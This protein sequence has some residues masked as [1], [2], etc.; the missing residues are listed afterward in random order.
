MSC[1]L[2]VKLLSRIFFIH[3]NGM[4]KKNFVFMQECLICVKNTEISKKIFKSSKTNK[5]GLLG[6]L[7]HAPSY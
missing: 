1:T 2:Y 4:S 3:I 7:K 5:S 6:I